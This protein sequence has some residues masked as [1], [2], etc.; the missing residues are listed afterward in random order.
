MAQRK[1]YYSFHDIPFQQ[2]PY[3]SSSE[4]TGVRFSRTE[5]IHIFIAMAVL[6]V[7]FSFA[8]TAGYP[9]HASISEVLSNLPLAF[10]SI[11]TAFFFHE[12]AHKLVAQHYRLWSEFRMY[13]KGL[14]L[15]LFL[16]VAFGVVFAA[17][18]AVQI[19]GSANREEIGRISLAGPSTN[20]VIALVC[21]PFSIVATGFFKDALWFI[22]Y[23]N[24]FLAFF[25]LIPF[26]PLDGKK[27]FHWRIDV[28]A[29]L[30]ITSVLLLIV[31]FG[32]L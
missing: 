4:G 32:G 10:L 1:I 23:I 21:L 26:G 8:I 22:S 13:P 25:N 9:Q 27:I 24:S 20:L 14:L 17:P 11:I 12:M 15:A 7:T 18:G 5:L 3:L 30:I 2:D 19:F 16:G 28:W 29:A 6:T 31:A